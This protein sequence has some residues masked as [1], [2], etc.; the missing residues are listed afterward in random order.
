MY[1][2]RGAYTSNDAIV[3]TGSVKVT[4][5][6]SVGGAW[7]FINSVLGKTNNTSL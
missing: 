7:W 3:Y 2:R 4:I 1:Y 5:Q 6:Q